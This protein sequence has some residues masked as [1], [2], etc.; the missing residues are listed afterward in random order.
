MK[1]KISFIGILVL[2][3]VSG[4][5]GLEQAPVSPSNPA[6]PT[7]TP[8]K[9]AAWVALENGTYGDL[10]CAQNL[11]FAA[12]PT[13]AQAREAFSGC[14][15]DASSAKRSSLG[16]GLL[17][18]YAWYIYPPYYYNQQYYSNYNQQYY[19][20]PTY[21]NNNYGCVLFFGRQAV[22]WNFNCISYIGGYGNS[23]VGNNYNSYCTSNC[24]YSLD[25]YCYQRCGNYVY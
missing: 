15:V 13:A 3:L 18:A 16:R 14:V 19:S 5:G 11:Q 1:R 23:Y 17:A 20:S 7:A 2:V 21:N 9:R 25:P 8:A 4:C 22:N 10:T 6:A 24:L 12:D